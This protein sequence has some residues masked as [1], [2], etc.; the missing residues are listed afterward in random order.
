[1]SPTCMYTCDLQGLPTIYNSFDVIVTNNCI[2]GKP[3]WRFII[4]F[5]DGRYNDNRE[6]IYEITFKNILILFCVELYTIVCIFDNNI[7]C[8]LYKYQTPGYDGWVHWFFEACIPMLVFLEY[9]P[10]CFLVLHGGNLS[11]N[12]DWVST[13]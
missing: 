1:M 4:S 6:E 2:L 9:S 11:S 8:C 12:N 7:Q 5:Y 10:P 3:F 13:P